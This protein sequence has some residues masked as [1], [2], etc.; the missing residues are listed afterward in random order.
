MNTLELTGLIV[1]FVIL[2]MVSLYHAW[3][4]KNGHRKRSFLLERNLYAP[5]DAH[6]GD[7]PLGLGLLLAALGLAM[8]SQEGNIAEV[9]FWRTMFFVGFFGGVGLSVLFAIFKPKFVKPKWLLWLEAHYDRATVAYMFD[10]AR[11][12]PKSWEWKISTQEGLEK[13]AAEMAQQYEAQVF[14]RPRNS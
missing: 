1:F 11:R 9:R 2:G 8:G 6:Y 3:Q 4:V 10:Q 12:N 14:I 13:W 5:K 7:F